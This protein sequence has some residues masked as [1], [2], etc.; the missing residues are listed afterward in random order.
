MVK[1]RVKLKNINDSNEL[2]IKTWLPIGT[3]YYN[4]NDI[5]SDI[6]KYFYGTWERVK[7]FFPFA[8]DESDPDFSKS[9]KTGGEKTHTLTVDEMPEHN[10]PIK[11]DQASTGGTDWLKSGGGS[12]GP[13]SSNGYV[14]NRG[15][16]QPHNNMPPYRTFYAWI[17]VS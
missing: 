13:Y 12:G 7:G 4:E 2:I 17:R 14:E 1:T 5:T 16:S 10:H 8:V 15:K 11:F 6:D 9:N 3:L